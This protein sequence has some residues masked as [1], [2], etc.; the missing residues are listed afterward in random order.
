MLRHFDLS[1][2]L[3]RSGSVQ[4]DGVAV[5]SAVDDDL[6]VVVFEVRVIDM[7]CPCRV[8]KCLVND[9]LLQFASV[10]YESRIRRRIR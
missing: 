5:G 3:D 10:T 7:P 9:S 4:P 6:Q 8:V 2:R 1:S